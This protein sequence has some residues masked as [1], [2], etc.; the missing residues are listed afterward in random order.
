[1]DGWIR[2]TRRLD[3]LL[4]RGALNVLPVTGGRD[5]MVGGDWGGGGGQGKK[6]A[7]ECH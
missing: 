6:V 3:H 4:L 2:Q 5:R 7:E 1:M